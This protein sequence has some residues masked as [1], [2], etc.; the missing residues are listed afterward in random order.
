MKKIGIYFIIAGLIY[1]ILTSLGIRFWHMGQLQKYIVPAV[2]ASGIL[3]Y[4]F[5][6]L[7]RWFSGNPSN[8][9]TSKNVIADNIDEKNRHRMKPNYK[10]VIYGVSLV[11]IVTAVIVLYQTKGDQFKTK[12]NQAKENPSTESTPETKQALSED[13]VTDNPTT[14]NEIPPVNNRDESA[15]TTI[16]EELPGEDDGIAITDTEKNEYSQDEIQ[17]DAV[18]FIEDDTDD[19][20]NSTEYDNSP[21]SMGEYDDPELEKLYNIGINGSTKELPLLIEALKNPTAEIREVALNSIGMLGAKVAGTAMPHL[22]NAMDDKETSVRVAAILAVIDLYPTGENKDQALAKLK[23][24]QNDKDE[25][26]RFLV[27]EALM[28]LN[29]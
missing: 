21:G 14:K 8:E 25:E 29:E 17:D 23:T 18:I 2:M 22:I 26:I 27:E 12:L 5:G 24:M 11:V 15:Y 28:I 10:K 9:T 20:S 4:L 13:K 6:Y 3:M 16:T 1:G 19:F 7:S